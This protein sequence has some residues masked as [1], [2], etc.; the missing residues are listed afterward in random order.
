[1]QIVNDFTVFYFIYPTFIDSSF[2]SKEQKTL[3]SI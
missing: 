1:M 3:V 2:D